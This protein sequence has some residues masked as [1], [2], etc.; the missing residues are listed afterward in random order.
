MEWN[1]ELAGNLHKLGYIARFRG[2][3]N[4]AARLFTESLTMQQDMGNKQGVIEC[5]VG[6]AGLATVTGYTE[7]AT[8]LFAAAEQSLAEIGAPLG[9]ADLAELE[10]DLSIIQDK[11]NGDRF[12]HAW[13]MGTKFSMKQALSQA[14]AIADKLITREENSLH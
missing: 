9:P 13:T 2:D 4:K 10:R 11:I 12:T 8:K 5:L 14:E 7:D 3:F 1:L 6:L